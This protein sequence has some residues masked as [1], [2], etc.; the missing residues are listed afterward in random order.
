MLLLM[1]LSLGAWLVLL[2]Q[3][4]SMTASNTDV[5]MDDSIGLMPGL[6]TDTSGMTPFMSNVGHLAGFVAAWSVM[7]AAMMLPSAAPMILLYQGTTAA[8]SGARL[9]FL[10]TWMF[11]LG[12]LLVWASF[13]MPVFAAQQLIANMMLAGNGAALSTYGT[14]AVLIVAGA[15][16]FTPLKQVCLR[17]CQS[18]VGFLMTHWNPGLLGALHTSLH[19]AAYCIGCCWGLMAIL[20]GAGAMGLQWALLIA[21]I[22]AAEKLLTNGQLAARISGAGFL[23]LGIAVLAQPGLAMWLR[24]GGM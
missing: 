8:H 9:A 2:T 18:P 12:Y 7:M 5:I 10:P 20:V 1:T 11:A 24:S 22:V 17:S 15:Y 23:V 6:N 16:Q 21:A 19:H 4:L 3:S 13:G 14:S